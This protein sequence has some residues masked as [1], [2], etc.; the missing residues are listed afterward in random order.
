MSVM[1]YVLTLTACV[2]LALPTGWCC[3]FSF[4][5]PTPPAAKT[6]ADCCTSCCSKT[7]PEREEAPARVPVTWCCC[8]NLVPMRDDGVAK[9]TPDVAVVALAMV[10]AP[11]ISDH[12]HTR[13]AEVC[14]S[15]PRPL[16]VLRCLWLC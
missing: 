3:L 7:K 15:P 9:V 2:L 16:H 5:N 12:F 11:V 8:E 4:T 10:E 14:L 13:P 6:D 1:R